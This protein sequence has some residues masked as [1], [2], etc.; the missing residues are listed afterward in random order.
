M[1][2]IIRN[3]QENDLAALTELYN[4]YIENTAITFDLKPYTVAERKIW[5][6]HYNK[7]PRHRL[8]VAEIAGTVLGYASSSQFHPKEA[9]QTS[10]ETTIYLHPE[11]KGKQVGTRLYEQLFIEIS[12]ADVHR[13]YAGITVPNPAS[14][15]FHEKL[16]FKTAAVY[17]EVGRKFDKFHDVH[18]LEKEL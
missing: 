4:F 3:A 16:G 17:K 6:E 9:Y 13:A 15:A 18:W 12:E 14:F 1:N 2:L 7:N 8:L 10:V 5:F 11:H